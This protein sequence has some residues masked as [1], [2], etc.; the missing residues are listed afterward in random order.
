MTEP[1]KT[2]GYHLTEI[3]KGEYGEISKIQEELDELKDANRQGS[4]ILELVEL[5]DLLGAME[6]YIE[7]HF[8]NIRM[9]DLFLFSRITQRAFKSGERK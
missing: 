5:A 8:P 6:G 7:K 1:L 4:R 9:V 2:P 3:K